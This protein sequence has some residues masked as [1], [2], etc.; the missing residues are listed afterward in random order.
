VVKHLGQEQKTQAKLREA[1]FQAHPD[2]RAGNK[3]PAIDDILKAKVP[4]LDAFI[5]EVLRASNPS[6]IVSKMSLEDMTI[7]GHHVPKGTAVLFTTFGPTLNSSGAHVDESLRSESSQKHKDEGF[8]D[9]SESEFPAEEFH[10]ERWLRPSPDGQG[11]LAFD[12]KAGPM[13]TFSAGPRMCWGKRLAYMELKLIVTLL[14]WNFVFDKLP[15]ELYDD[16]VDDDLFIKPRHCRVQL[17][18]VPPPEKVQ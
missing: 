8:S 7:L 6:M 1:L 4:Y 14:V 18:S 5:E 17:S 3:Q 11:E 16:D 12:S 2:A 15:A 10:P 9:W 13:L